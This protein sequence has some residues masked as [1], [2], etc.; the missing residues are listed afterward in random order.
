MIGLN[1][2]IR[3]LVKKIRFISTKKRTISENRPAPSARPV[4]HHPYSRII[5]FSSSLILNY[6]T[7]PAY[8]RP[9]L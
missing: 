1:W 9:E 3:F 7:S 5:C 2:Y 4:F 8:P 6:R